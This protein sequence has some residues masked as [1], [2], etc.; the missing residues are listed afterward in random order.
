MRCVIPAPEVVDITANPSPTT[1]VSTVLQC[2]QAADAH[3]LQGTSFRF[4]LKSIF[5][6]QCL[7]CID[8]DTPPSTTKLPSRRHTSH[9]PRHVCARENIG[10]SGQGGNTT[11]QSQAPTTMPAGHH[12]MLTSEDNITP[13]I[14]G[15]EQDNAGQAVL[16]ECITIH[17][18]PR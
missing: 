17:G 18:H 3:G 4:R 7:E 14:C 5:L 8:E 1:P 9:T 16:R 11:C 15:D 13:V 2:S 6:A 12:N 10:A